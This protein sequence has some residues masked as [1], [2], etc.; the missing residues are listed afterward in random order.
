M[1]SYIYNLY[2]KIKIINDNYDDIKYTIENI[3]HIPDYVYDL[4]QSKYVP[5]IIKDR[6]LINI[7]IFLVKFKYK[8]LSSK[9]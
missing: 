2:H 7:N 4:L 9:I 3:N 8:N 6:L 1:N 5:K